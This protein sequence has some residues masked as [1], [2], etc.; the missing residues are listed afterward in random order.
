MKNKPVPGS[1]FGLL[2]MLLGVPA[3]SVCYTLLRQD[4]RARLD[5]R[6]PPPPK[7]EEREE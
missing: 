6:S 3:A 1:L 4:V 5:R 2:G 7:Q